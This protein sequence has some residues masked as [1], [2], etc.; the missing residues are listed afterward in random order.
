MFTWQQHAGFMHAV[1]LCHRMPCSL[2]SSFAS[3]VTGSPDPS[4]F[5]IITVMSCLFMHAGTPLQRLLPTSQS[6]V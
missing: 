1:R 2:D 3:W 6:R 4:K 5:V